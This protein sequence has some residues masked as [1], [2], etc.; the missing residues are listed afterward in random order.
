MK[1]QGKQYFCRAIKLNLKFLKTV[2]IIYTNWSATLT[3]LGEQGSECKKVRVPMLNSVHHKNAYK[4]IL[5]VTLL[6]ITGR[7]EKNT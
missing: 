2:W 4:N 5:Y 7:L 3:P 6:Y 1:W